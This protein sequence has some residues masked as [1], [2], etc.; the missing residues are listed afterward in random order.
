[1]RIPDVTSEAIR[2]ETGVR[3]KDEVS[4]HYDPM[5]AKLVVWG[6]DREEALAILR[7]KL[8][9]YNV[10]KLNGERQERA[11]LTMLSAHIYASFQIAGLDTNIEFI[12]D[13]CSHPDFAKGQVHTG[14]IQEHY[15]ELLPKLN[16][17]SEIAAQAALAT[18][19]HGDACSLRASVKTVDPFSPF[20]TETGLRLNHPLTRVFSFNT[21]GN[22]ITVE[23]KY[24][25]PEVY[26]MRIN[27]IGSWRR[28]T[29]T[30][31]KIGDSLELAT[32]ID[33]M[34]TRARIVKIRNKLYLFTKA[35]NIK[36]E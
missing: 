26:S 10:S 25:E 17:P 32:E 23:V 5:I 21:C 2:V 16:I 22:D 31:K 24:I 34:I 6:N 3:E 12:K 20:A 28:V 8:S 15:Q 7:I 14:F 1:M 18:I 19:L 29:G 9:E 11:L 33:E 27:N 4:V 36:L 35:S 13:L 30:L